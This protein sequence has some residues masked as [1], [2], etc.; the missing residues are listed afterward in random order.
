MK[1]SPILYARGE[2][3]KLSLSDIS[4]L[5][6]PDESYDS[7]PVLE[8]LKELTGFD[9]V[10]GNQADK[11]SISVAQKRSKLEIS[12][13]PDFKSYLEHVSRDEIAKLGNGT[14]AFLIFGSPN[15]QENSLNQIVIAQRTSGN[16]RFSVVFD[17]VA[18]TD[19]SS[20]VISDLKPL[21]AFKEVP[22]PKPPESVVKQRVKPKDSAWVNN[23]DPEIEFEM[24]SHWE[25]FSQLTTKRPS[26]K[27]VS[28][29]RDP[30][31]T[32]M[33]TNPH[34]REMRDDIKYRCKKDGVE[35]T[36]LFLLESSF[37]TG[38]PAS[39]PWYYLIRNQL[40][41]QHIVSKGKLKELIGLAKDDK[42]FHNSTAECFASKLFRYQRS[43]GVTPEQI[44]DAVNFK[45]VSKNKYHAFAKPYFDYAA[46]AE[47]RDLAKAAIRAI[48][49]Q[50]PANGI[51]T[52][53]ADIKPQEPANGLKL[54][55]K[56]WGEYALEALTAT[57]IKRKDLIDIFEA[58]LAFDP[59]KV[60]ETCA[61]DICNVIGEIATSPLIIQTANDYLFSG[62]YRNLIKNFLLRNLRLEES[63]RHPVALVL[64][65]DE[66]IRRMANL[67][68]EINAPKIALDKPSNDL[69]LYSKE[70]SEY[71]LKALT[72]QEIEPKKLDDIFEAALAFDPKKV[73]EDYDPDINMVI[74][75]I[76]VS[77]TVQELV[78]DKLDSRKD[79]VDFL[80]KNSKLEQ[81]KRHPFARALLD[82]DLIRELT[83]A[84]EA[85]NQL[86]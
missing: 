17:S 83:A 25:A 12:L 27:A 80:S 52:N 56:E 79:L 23:W 41:I 43:K 4:S 18:E 29:F 32:F 53:A 61:P 73:N 28:R 16:D 13:S 77:P 6:Q 72:D 39:G 34:L 1:V 35:K 75:A 8:R 81:N 50:T 78:L 2:S 74:M 38:V 46:N 42:N 59:K 31:L 69:K 70:W 24:S 60:D 19:A 54:Y 44:G 10:N 45:W 14:P 36:A 21:V 22:Y 71:A 62:K 82:E 7:K 68:Q 33:L 63:Q 26:K 49:E 55:S 57:D 65:K 30:L 85:C 5:S 47:I 84:L 40:P 66:S 9:Y 20:E 64:L 58:A 3:A 51:E 37:Q 76:G 67:P 48:E 11:K 86:P 15:G